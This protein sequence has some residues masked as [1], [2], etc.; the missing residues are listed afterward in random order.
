MSAPEWV[1]AIVRSEKKKRGIPLEPKLLNGNY[2]LYI[3][4][5]KYD[6]SKKGAR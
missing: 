4:T 3:A 2:Y 1:E 5:S 6:R